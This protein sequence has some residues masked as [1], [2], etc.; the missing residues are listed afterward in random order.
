MIGNDVIDIIQS[1]K[2]SNWQRKGYL[3]KIF[4]SQEQL[5]IS[6]A[7]DPEIMVWLLWSM[8][9]AAY[10]IYNRQTKIRAYIPQKLICS[11]ISLNHD[12]SSG[13]V[14]CAENSYYTKTFIAPETLH[15]I[16][17]QSLDSLNNVV[18][19]ENKN[20]IKDISGIP[21]L[22]SSL[23]NTFQDVSISHHGKFEKVVTIR[24]AF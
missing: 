17:V 2:E 24:P 21:Y 6:N 3:Q 11:I 14:N 16:A 7:P 18:E 13:T 9:E 4:T 22:T 5:L 1:R 19:I 8:K 15:T 20:I 10:K 12:Y 23:S